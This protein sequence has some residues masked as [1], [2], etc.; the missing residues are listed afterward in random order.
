MNLEKAAVLGPQRLMGEE[1]MFF[2]FLSL[3]WWKQAGH[4]VGGGPFLPGNSLLKPQALLDFCGSSWGMSSTLSLPHWL[5]AALTILG[6][7]QRCLAMGVSSLV[8]PS[9]HRVPLGWNGQFVWKRR[10]APPQ[11]AQ[12][13][14]VKTGRRWA[15]HPRAPSDT[16]YAA[17][18][19]S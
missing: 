10:V 18:V 9:P 15:S 11:V 7:Y 4:S 12:T 14:E 17:P 8:P 13:V 1:R 3:P 16:V 2:H 5:G 19:P 6:G